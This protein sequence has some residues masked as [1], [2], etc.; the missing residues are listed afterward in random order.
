V[1]RE[2][3]QS[4][5][6][7]VDTAVLRSVRCASF[8]QGALS[9]KLVRFVTNASMHDAG[10][11]VVERQI[12]GGSFG[13]VFAGSWKGVPIVLKRANVRVPYSDETVKNRKGF[14]VGDR[15]RGRYATP[16]DFP[17]HGCSPYRGLR[18]CRWGLGFCPSIKGHFLS[19]RA[20]P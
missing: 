9:R 15:S 14:R 3:Q 16:A 13:G 10:D 7:V 4:R 17:L 6:A 20:K 18:V 12:G 11:I 19:R 1:R 8:V 5:T 2:E